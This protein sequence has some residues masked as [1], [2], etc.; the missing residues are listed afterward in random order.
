MQLK[1]LYGN[2]YFYYII[3]YIINI[4]IWKALLLNVGL[5]QYTYTAVLGVVRLTLNCGHIL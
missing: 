4:I 5:Q 1:V 3:I 2:I